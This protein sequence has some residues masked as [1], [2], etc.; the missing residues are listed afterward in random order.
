MVTATFDPAT[1]HNVTLSN[2]NL[3]VTS[4]GDS[5]GVAQGVMVSS[6]AGKTSGKYYF[7]VTITTTGPVDQ[8]GNNGFGVST[9]GNS[10]SNLINNDGIG[11]VQCFWTDSGIWAN[12]ILVNTIG[13]HGFSQGDVF[14][15]AVDLDNRNA[16]FIPVAGSLLGRNWNG[17]PTGDPVTNTFGAP[18][19]A[20]TIVPYGAFDFCD[21]ND[22]QTAN[23]GATAFVGTVPSGFTSGWPAAGVV[24]APFNVRAFG[25]VGLAQMD[26]SQQYRFS[27]DMA[28]ISE[29]QP[30]WTQI[31][32]TNGVTPVSIS[33]PG[34]GADT[35]KV[36]GIEVA[37]GNQIRYELQL[38]P[39]ASNARVPG[40]L[41][42]R[43]S[44]F[45]YIA[46]ADGS[47]FRFVDAAS[48]P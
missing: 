41:S 46:W 3:T 17:H 4:P 20:G 13:S 19:V 27:D 29:D 38:G 14:G 1:V 31:M 40:N 45:S 32:A 22:A 42:R 23:F 25:Y 35:A 48:F 39:N 15:I 24:A 16:W 18:I 36:L 43:M 2:G 10:Y 7:E 37:D 33:F 30:V 28:W 6:A 11:G 12:S 9:V 21:P 26:V 5:L 34:P 44:G 47:I 8:G